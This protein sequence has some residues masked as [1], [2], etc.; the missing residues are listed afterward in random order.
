MT[1]ND[2]SLDREK[3]ARRQF[4]MRC[5]KWAAITPPAVT[6]MLSVADRNYAVASSGWRGSDDGERRGRRQGHHWHHRKWRRHR[7]AN[8][9]F[10]NGG[11]DGVPGRSPHND[12]DR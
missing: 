6:L 9:G 12:L 11:G 5:G 1:Q 4:L 8:N 7:H 3:E 2:S 10:G